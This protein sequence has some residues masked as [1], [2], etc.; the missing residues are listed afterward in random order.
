MKILQSQRWP[1]QRHCTYINTHIHTYIF[2]V[3]VV[4]LITLNIQAIPITDIAT[5]KQLALVVSTSVC[6]HGQDKHSLWKAVM[7]RNQTKITNGFQSFHSFYWPSD[8][9]PT[10]RILCTVI[11]MQ[12]YE[13][14]LL[15]EFTSISTHGPW[16]FSYS[17]PVA[18]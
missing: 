8:N 15:R 12:I 14:C 4:Q 2:I 13:L 18:N 16:Q 5:H 10:L 7:F 9:N 11:I 17:S 1:W 6:I 3:S